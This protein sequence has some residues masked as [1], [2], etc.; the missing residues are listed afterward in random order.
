ME[1]FGE[2]SLSEDRLP[3]DVLAEDEGVTLS[4]FRN[5]FWV[6]DSSSENARM[7]F[8]FLPKYIIGFHTT[9]DLAIITGM[10]FRKSDT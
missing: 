5:D 10:M 1:S 8:I 7:N 6:L 2:E 3:E 4:S 9:D